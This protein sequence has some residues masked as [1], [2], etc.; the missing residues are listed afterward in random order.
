MKQILQ[1]LRT[2]TI[3]LL[4]TA[5]PR[6]LS[7]HCLIATRRSLIS[8]GTERM[9]VEFGQ[10]NLLKKIRSQPEKAQ[11]VLDKIRTDGLF[12]TLETVFKRL[13]EPLPLG[14]CNVGRV[15]ETGEGV[16]EFSVGD[17]VSSNGPHAEIVCVPRNLCTKI[18]ENVSND[19][20]T[21]TVLGSIALQ[22]IRLSKPGLGEKFIVFGSGLIGLLA[23]QL[24]RVSGCNVLAIDLN[25]QRLVTA[26]SLGAITCNASK[27]DPISSATAWTSGKGVDG[28]IIS[29]SAKTDEIIHQAAQMCRK[30]GRIVLVGVVGLN[31]RRRDFYEKELTFQ[32]SCSY[33]PGRYDPG[34]EEQGHDYPIGFVRWTEQRNFEAVLGAMASGQLRVDNLITHRFKFENAVQAYKT[35]T[36]DQNA[37]GVVLEYPDKVEVQDTVS[38]P[39][40]SSSKASK[41]VAALIGA[42]NFAKMTMA[43]AL[44]KTSARLK[45]ICDHK[46]VTAATHLARNYNF[47]NVSSDFDNVLSD[48]EVNTIFIA[49]NHD[50]HAS[51][52]C[53]ALS[54]GKHIFVEKPLAIDLNGLEQV[55][56]TARSHIEQQLMVGFN[57]RFSPHIRK[58]KE[59][60]K[61]RNEPL[62]M[63]YGINAGVIPPNTWIHDPVIGG[64][65]IIGEACHFIDILSYIAESRIVAVGAV[66]MGEGV[67]VKDDKMSIILGFEDGSIGTIN[68]FANG[69][70]SY[71]KEII[72]VF[73]QGRVLRLKNFRETQSFGF[74]KLRKFKTWRQ[75]KGHATEFTA[76]VDRVSSGGPPI[77]SLPDLVNVTLASFAAVASAREGRQIILEHEYR[78]LYIR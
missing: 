1:N 35:I 46:N 53:K 14:Y 29:A 27:G 57:R 69:A 58:I 21:F 23:I 39:V 18:P 22:G 70:K 66:K 36:S 67:A 76:F 26:R 34:Y 2:G 41:C 65:R 60:L 24:L 71:P 9:L 12:P 20:A 37:L 63:H 52:T 31:L 54:A 49:T 51:L 77:I 47:E 15:I 17:R 28:V 56:D 42:G 25:D 19:E 73:S 33:G 5:A 8:A 10:A 68:Y 4:D 6:C 43:P 11:Q 50:S 38:L 7:G 74:P 30:R 59:L 32:V 16:T 64:G 75:D 72:E 44:V 45:Y 40:K 55:I 48:S 13:D 78:N 62:A 3:E 61:G